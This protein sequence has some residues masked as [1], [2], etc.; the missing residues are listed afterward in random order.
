[1]VITDS[2]LYRMVYKLSKPDRDYLLR[3]LL[4]HSEITEHQYR[5][6]KEHMRELRDFVIL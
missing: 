5:L 6:F 4:N 1:M 3:S 2:S